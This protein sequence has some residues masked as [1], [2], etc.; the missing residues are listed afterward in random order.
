MAL[1][2]A[3][4][5]GV[6]AHLFAAINLSLAALRQPNFAPDSLLAWSAPFAIG[7]FTALVYVF[8]HHAL[9][10]RTPRAQSLLVRFASIVFAVFFLLVIA[11]FAYATSSLFLWGTFTISLS[12]FVFLNTVCFLARRKPLGTQASVQARE[13]DDRKAASARARWTIGL[14]VPAFVIALSVWISAPVVGRILGSM[15]VA[16]FALGAV[17]AAIN[18]FEFAIAW[19][20]ARKWFGEG[21][22]P[23]V[24]AGIVALGILNAW[25]HPFHRVRLCD[26]GGCPVPKSAAVYPHSPDDRPSVE[27]AAKAWYAQAKTAFV[28]AHHGRVDESDRVPMVIVATAGGGIRAALDGDGSRTDQEGSRQERPSP[29]SLRDQRGFGR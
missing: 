1:L 4:L 22:K 28:Q 23:Y 11:I 12:A 9:S 15:V 18:V 29:L 6:C 21:A 3:R 17:L 16:Y 20:I 27:K 26:G 10:E 19:A 7:V 13:D 5:L 24:V 2:V 14:F 25:L 8:D